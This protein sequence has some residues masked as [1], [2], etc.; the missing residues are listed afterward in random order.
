[1]P[2]AEVA[3]RRPQVMLTVWRKQWVYPLLFFVVFATIEVTFLSSAILKVPKGGWFSLMMAGIYG[4]AL[5]HVQ[6]SLRVHMGCSL[7]RW[8]ATRSMQ[9]AALPFL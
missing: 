2:K 6:C 1:M 8:H 5:L 4:E 3:R 9:A 7:G